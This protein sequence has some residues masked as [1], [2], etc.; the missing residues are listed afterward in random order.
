MSNNT[1]T[2]PVSLIIDTPNN[3]EL[4]EKIRK[5]LN[6]QISSDKSIFPENYEYTDEY[7]KKQYVDPYHPLKK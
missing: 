3:A 5:V 4:G 7:Y 6:Q 1:I 2:I